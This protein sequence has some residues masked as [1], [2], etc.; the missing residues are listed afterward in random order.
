M[1][2]R[3]SRQ[4]R[5]EFLKQAGCMGAALCLAAERLF[6]RRQASPASG[7]ETS[8]AF[9]FRTV[10]VRHVRDLQEWMNK[11]DG[12]GRLSANKTWRSYVNSFQYAAPKALAEARSLIIMATPLKIARIVFHAAGQKHVVRI[13]CGYVDDGLRLADYQS[14]LFQKGV[15]PKDSKLELARLPLKQLAVRSGLAAYGRNNITFIDGYGSFHQLLAFYTD[16]PLE[17][18]WGPLKLLRECKGCSIC[19][20]ECPTG[21]IRQG[22]FV[23]DPAKCITLYNELPDPMPS[24]I[25][26]SAHN[27]LV[28]CLKCQLPCPGDEEAAKDFWDLGEV[29]EAETAALLGGT[30]DAK[31][32]Q[33]LKDRFKRIGGGDNLP[34]IARNLKLVLDAGPGAKMTKA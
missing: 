1:Q 17:E 14:M 30:V 11:L 9:Q 6:P 31:T 26:A 20:K 21:A 16:R 22:D 5:R 15:V 3:R 19:L 25:P 7:T 27:A 29:P 24:W 32:E 34:Y 13:P 12:A 28:G 4:S 2:E 18:H 10:S 33:A 8:P 23:I